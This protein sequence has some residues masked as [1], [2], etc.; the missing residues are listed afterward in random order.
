MSQTLYLRTVIQLSWRERMTMLRTGRIAISATV[1]PNR[2]E[3]VK[4]SPFPGSQVAAAHWIAA[5]R[6]TSS[7]RTINGRQHRT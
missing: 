5:G 6:A 7:A 4:A 2:V 1:Y 3:D